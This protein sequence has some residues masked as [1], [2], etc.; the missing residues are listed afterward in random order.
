MKLWYLIVREEGLME[1]KH[2]VELQ[3][4]IMERLRELMRR[5]KEEDD[6]RPIG[7]LSYIGGWLEAANRDLFSRLT[8]EG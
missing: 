1:K 4:E 2:P 5:A 7:V 8:K 6:W 3:D